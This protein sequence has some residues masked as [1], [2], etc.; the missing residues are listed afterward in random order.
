[1]RENITELAPGWEGV[2]G[3]A[4]IDALDDRVAQVAVAAPNAGISSPL[5]ATAA[6]DVSLLEGR[7]V[8]VHT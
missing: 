7:E 3:S 1:M 8:L 2:L 4:S 6:M 5:A